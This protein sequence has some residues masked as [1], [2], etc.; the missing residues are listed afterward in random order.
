MILNALVRLLLFD[1]VVDP[2]A[3]LLLV[4]VLEFLQLFG[5]TFFVA[6]IDVDVYIYVS[7]IYK[8][9]LFLVLGFSYLLGYRVVEGFEAVEL[10]RLQ[11]LDHLL[12][13]LLGTLGGRMDACPSAI[14][15]NKNDNVTFHRNFYITPGLPGQPYIAQ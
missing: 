9:L 5:E 11:R 7:M 1:I 15:E 3:E 2:G 8:D 4:H 6:I 10:V 14:Q 12:L 13:P